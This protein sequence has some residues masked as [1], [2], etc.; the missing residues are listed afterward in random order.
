MPSEESQ[1]RLKKLAELE[2]RFK[3]SRQNLLRA[4]QTARD[5]LRTKKKT[6]KK[7]NPTTGQ[8]RKTEDVPGVETETKPVLSEVGWTLQHPPQPQVSSIGRGG[9]DLV[10]QML[11][12]RRQA[13]VAQ[14]IPAQAA[15]SFNGP[16]SPIVQL[17]GE[18]VMAQLMCDL[19]RT[20][21]LVPTV[22]PGYHSMVSPPQPHLSALGLT[23]ASLGS[24]LFARNAAP[25]SPLAVSLNEQNAL[26]LSSLLAAPGLGTSSF[27][28]QITV[29]NL[30][31]GL[32][33]TR[34]KR[35]RLF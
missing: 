23:A 21:I 13:S 19:G 6:S 27:A 25:P 12:L 33:E 3:E 22:Q 2:R 26:L 17:L 7:A 35:Q 30:S 28:G 5:K 8:K 10:L 11:A 15:A 24:F 9:D 4:Q 18:Q 16:S 32:L 29:D 31:R 1:S 14:G 20:R 34:S